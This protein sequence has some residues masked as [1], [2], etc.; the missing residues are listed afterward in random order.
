MSHTV[1]VKDDGN[2]KCNGPIIS[3]F[4]DLCSPST[5]MLARFVFGKL[6][7]SP[8]EYSS[9]D[10]Y[11]KDAILEIRAVGPW[12]RHVSEHAIHPHHRTPLTRLNSQTSHDFRDLPASNRPF[13]TLFAR[14]GGNGSWLE[15][16]RLRGSRTGAIA[17]R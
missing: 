1:T 4:V 3:D 6:H 12:G 14:M 2:H 5:P 17:R 10:C 9:L 13:F 8:L 15:A 11:F 16:I 7:I